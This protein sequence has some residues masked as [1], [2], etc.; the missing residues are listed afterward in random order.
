MKDQLPKHPGGYD[1]AHNILLEH[2]VTTGLVGPLT[3]AAVF[4]R[5]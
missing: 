1:K 4:V 3:Y 2:L 5:A